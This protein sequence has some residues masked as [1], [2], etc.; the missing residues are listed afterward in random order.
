MANTQ[1]TV[2]LFVANQVLTAAQQNLSAGT[3]VPVFATTVTRDAAFGGSNKALAKGQLAYIE[4]T[5][6]VQYYDG[7]AWAT[8][9]PSSAKLGQTVQSTITGQVVS[10]STSYVTTTLNVTITPSS[11]SSKVLLIYS[12]PT[13]ITTGQTTYLTIFRGTVAGTNLSGAEGLA[14]MNNIV[15]SGTQTDG[16]QMI[17]IDSPATTSATTYTAGFKVSGGTGTANSGAAGMGVM[18]AIE[19]LP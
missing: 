18:I 14:Q 10:T 1:T 4:A 8:V 9:G 5:N 11:A 2:P 15:A 6:I 12:S 7:A 17:Y 19:V 13:G 16:T 3:G